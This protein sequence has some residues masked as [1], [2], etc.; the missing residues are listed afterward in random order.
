MDLRDLLTKSLAQNECIVEARG[1]F[2]MNYNQTSF[3]IYGP[4]SDTDTLIK[5]DARRVFIFIQ[6]FN[7][8]KSILRIFGDLMQNIEISFEKIDVVEGRE[9]VKHFCD[10]CSDSLSNLILKNCKENVLNDLKATFR[11]VKTI[12]LSTLASSKL[13]F[14]PPVIKLNET[15]PNLNHLNLGPTK[16]TD[17]ELIGGTFS[18]L[19]HLNVEVP[20]TFKQKSRP[21]DSYVLN[22]LQSN[23]QIETLILAKT[24]LK[25]LKIASQL[26][27]L[28]ALELNALSDQY[29]NYKG[30]P[31]QFDTV[32]SV[33]IESDYSNNIPENVHF[34]RIHELN[35]N[36]KRELN[37]KWIEFINNQ[38][39]N[40]IT[41]LKLDI[42]NITTVNLWS[43]ADTQT[44]LKRVSIE[45]FREFSAD[46]ILMFIRRSATL[47][48]LDL[49]IWIE[50]A[51]E[52]KLYENLQG[53]EWNISCSPPDG[54]KIS[55]TMER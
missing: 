36:I 44:N 18:E 47:I 48:K 31:V 1:F 26:P 11:N 24:T 40:N 54:K 45:C 9:I 46:D 6:S 23:P 50:E 37:G 52:K 39:N 10:N 7:V 8:I 22:L 19:N 30:K 3:K 33:T 35:L 27:R 21:D 32:E 34:N 49:K 5:E 14:S 41:D 43:I 29:F 4:F 15:F 55:I 25:L 38:V 53:G 2:K 51:E 17:W 28:R 16:V 13:K 20:R 12:T 42:I